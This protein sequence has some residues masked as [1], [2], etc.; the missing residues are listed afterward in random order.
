MK[1][2]VTLAILWLVLACA[3]PARAADEPTAEQKQ[4]WAALPE[5]DKQRMRENYEKWHKLGPDERRQLKENFDTFRKLPDRDRR[6]VVE[7]F[8]KFRSLP[9]ER[10]SKIRERYQQ[11][12]NLPPDVRQHRLQKLRDR[13]RRGAKPKEPGDA[14]SDKKQP[15]ERRPRDIIRKNRQR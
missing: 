5:A 14:Q 6:L 9:P 4:R 2:T 13:R 3:L 8:R 15:P 1:R 11:F 7:R 12:M 10:Q